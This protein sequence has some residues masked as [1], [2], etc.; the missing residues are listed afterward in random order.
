MA[1]T[2][3]L[4]AEDYTGLLKIIQALVTKDPNLEIVGVARTGPEVMNGAAALKPDVILMDHSL[5]GISGLECA[6]NIKHAHAKTK[7]LL[8]TTQDSPEWRS[9]ASEHGADECL[10]KD[11]MVSKLLPTIRS[12][13]RK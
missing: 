6:R 9:L 1:K 11:S 5:P 8:L 13:E 3:V 7:I 12:L 10:P 2:K 4:I